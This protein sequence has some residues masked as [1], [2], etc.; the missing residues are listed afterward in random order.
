MRLNKKALLLA[1]LITVSK[2]SFAAAPNWVAII[3]DGS[4]LD[5]ASVKHVGGKLLIWFVHNTTK[6]EVY[7]YAAV[8]TTYG[9]TY[10]ST[11][12]LFSIDCKV[13]R[14]AE[15]QIAYYT[16]PKMTGNFLGSITTPDS[17]VSFSYPIPGTVGSSEFDFACSRFARKK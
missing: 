10:S 4:W 12:D 3:P 16:E 2:L 13:G 8:G 11:A 7:P 6:P 17:A 5:A 9:A 15:L 1:L 14:W